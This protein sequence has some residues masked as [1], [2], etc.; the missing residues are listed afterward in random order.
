MGMAA[1]FL[2]KA[3][4]VRAASVAVQQETVAL[5]TNTQAQLVNA[6]AARA[7]AAHNNVQS[8]AAIFSQ[9]LPKHEGYLFYYHV[10][11]LMVWLLLGLSPWWFDC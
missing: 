9:H 10:S 8:A 3:N 11:V 2:E 7:N 6:N 4:S 1:V 5:T